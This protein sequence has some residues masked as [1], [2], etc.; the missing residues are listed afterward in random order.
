MGL[1]V[2]ISKLILAFM[3]LINPF[4]ALS[5]YL[6]LT[7]NHNT[8]E[9]RKIT[10]VAAL[11]VFIVITVFALT[12]GFLLKLLGISVGSFQ[13]GGG[14]LVLLIAISMMNGNSNPAKPDLGTSE[15]A[16]I[17][18]QQPKKRPKY[19]RYRRSTDCYSDDGWS[20]RYFYRDYL[21]L[22]SQKLLGHYFHYC[23]GSAYQ[24]DLLCRTDGIFPYQPLFRRY[25]S[26][27]TQPH[28]GYA[29]GRRVGGNY[30]G[31]TKSDFPAAYFITF[32]FYKGNRR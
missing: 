14:I 15:E 5:I 12:G 19:Q 10:S 30:R 32:P 27:D 25:R 8:K 11:T 21:C 3:V 29:A 26:D 18:I 23:G 22:G 28:Y 4:G 17:T 13:V 2:E 16:E 9:R 1:G 24:P 6:D 7:R 31:G 20:G